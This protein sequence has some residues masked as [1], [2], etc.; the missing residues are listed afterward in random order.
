MPTQSRLSLHAYLLQSGL[1]ASASRASIPALRLDSNDPICPR[2]VKPLTPITAMA[3][4]GSTPVTLILLR[5]VAL[6]RNL[7][8]RGG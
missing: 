5:C 3:T 8:R 2:F 1:G 6:E 4:L 7:R